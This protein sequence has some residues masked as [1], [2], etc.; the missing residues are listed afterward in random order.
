MSDDLLWQLPF[1]DVPELELQSEFGSLT[2]VPVEAGQS[3]H[4]ELS[5]GSADRIAV[6]IDKQGG[7]VRVALEPDHHGLWFGNW[8]AR[9]TLR[10]PRNVRAHVQTN[11]GS[12]SA[13]DLDQCELGIKANAGKIDLVNVHGLLHLGAEAG[14]VTGRNVA[15]FFD[16]E[17][18]AG[19]I[20]LEI[21]ALQPGE[22]RMRA[23]MGSVRLELA[24]GLDV[25]IETRTSLGSV[26][27]NYPSNQSAA[28]RLLVSTEMGSLRIDESMAQA[29]TTVQEVRPEAETEAETGETGET[30][31]RSDPELERVLK[32]VESGELS[33]QDADELLRAMGR[34]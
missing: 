14:A 28:A 12:V 16:V 24:R 10:V 13:R 23:T 20:R 11:A 5:P 2:L 26:R 1:D 6:H 32:M 29:R 25:C 15:G 18:Q 33:A 17:T 22:H 31:E 30:G 21:T 4:L 27:N 3:P 7:K 34:V 8:D 9:A 19:S